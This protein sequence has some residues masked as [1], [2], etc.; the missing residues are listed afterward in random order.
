MLGINKVI[1]MGNLGADPQINRTQRGTLVANLSIATTEQWQDAN[2]EKKEETEWHKVTL[3]GRLAEIAQQYL[4][5]GSTVYVEGSNRTTKYTDANGI[6]RYVTNI[7]AKSMQM[8]GG[9]TKQNNG[10]PYQN[11]NQGFNNGQQIPQ[12]GQQFPNNGYVNQ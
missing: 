3:F 1:V 8:V 7:V 12:G 5:K 6:E 2:G 4:V 11:N 10:Q 9:K